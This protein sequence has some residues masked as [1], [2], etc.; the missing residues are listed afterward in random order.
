MSNITAT[1]NLVAMTMYYWL[2]SSFYKRV[3]V[4]PPLK[5]VSFLDLTNLLLTKNLRYWLHQW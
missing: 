4:A 2:F 1:V 3:L 5:L